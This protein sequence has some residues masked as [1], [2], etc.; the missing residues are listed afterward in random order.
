MNNRLLKEK[1]H[2]DEMARIV[3]PLAEHKLCRLCVDK[4]MKYLPK[5]LWNGKKII[6]AACGE[7]RYTYYFAIKGANHVIGIDISSDYMKFGLKE[8]NIRVYNDILEDNRSSA[9]LMLIEGDVMDLSNFGKHSFDT[10]FIFNSLHHLPDVEKFIVQ[11]KDALKEDGYFVIVEPNGSNPF[12]FIINKIGKIVKYM[13]EDEEA[14]KIDCIKNMLCENG[15]TIQSIYP[16]NL[17]SEANYLLSWIIMRKNVALSRLILAMNYIYL[18]LDSIL[19]MT[20]FKMFQS[21]SWRVMFISQKE[22]KSSIL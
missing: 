16:M 12:R 4:H 17:F 1:K 5:S 21:L 10:V 8:K 7:A 11:V 18:P 14:F 9:N 2:Y 15:F 19:E 6:D 13:S 22:A 3:N 20:L